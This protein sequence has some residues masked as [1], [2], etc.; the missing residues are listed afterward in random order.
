MTADLYQN[1]TVEVP[2]AI[3][4]ERSD[5]T[6][7]TGNGSTEGDVFDNGTIDIAVDLVNPE[8]DTA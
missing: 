8:D 6:V 1:S 2:P 7:V 3:G 5:G 4:V